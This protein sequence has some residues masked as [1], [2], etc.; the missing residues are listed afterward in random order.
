MSCRR[1]ILAVLL[2]LAAAP[3]AAVDVHDTRLLAEPD[4]SADR[5]VFTYAGDLWTA[6][7]AGGTA[8]RLTADIGRERRPRF[9]PDGSLVAFSAEYDGNVDVYVIPAGGGEPRR[10][11]WH[12]GDDLVQG[13]TP[14]GSAVLFTSQRSVHT[15]SIAQLFTVP[16]GGGFPERLPV[17]R[18]SKAELSPGGETVAYL[19]LSEAF[20]QWKHYRGGRA[21]RIWLQDLD[22]ASVLQIP[23]PE[24]RCNDTDP[25]WAGGR[26]FFLS[27][28]DGEFNLY[29]FDR[30]AGTVE[31]RTFH[32]DFPVAS[33]AAGPGGIVY[34]QAGRLH[35][36]DPETGESRPLVVGVAADLPEARSRW[37]AGEEWIRHWDL[38]PSGAR[39]VFEFRGEIV[40]VPAEKGDPRNLTRTPGAHDRWPAWSPD[41]AR[42]AWFSDAGGEQAL[43]VAPAGGAGEARVYPLAG[44]GFYDRPLWSPDGTKIAFS[45]NAWALYWIDLDSGRVRE[46]SREVV[47]GPSKALRYDWSPDSRWLAFTRN[48]P[49]LFQELW[50]H[51]LD[52]GDDHLVTDGLSDAVEPAFD[53]GGRHLYFAASTD[54][55]PLRQWFAMSNADMEM[56][57][58][59]YVAVLRAGDPSPLAPESD[60]E[61][62]AAAGDEKG[63]KKDHPKDR[64]DDDDGDEPPRVTV[65]AAG[66]GQRI[67][68]LPLDAA[69]Y[70]DLQAG[71][72]GTLHYL[73][74]TGGRGRRDRGAT[75]QLCR[76]DLEEREEKVLVEDADAYRLATGG[77]K[78]LVQVNGAWSI[79]DA[80]SP[81]PGEGRLDV[82]AVRVRVVP[83]EEW[84]QICHEAWRINRDCFY[85]P[86]M[87]G[88]DWPGVR[89]KYAAFLP[90]LSC[91]DDLSRVLRWMGSELS[92]GHHYLWGGDHRR[93]AEAVPG[94]LLGADYEVAEGRYRFARVLGGLNWNPELR[95]PLTEPGVDVREGEFLLAVDGVDLRPPE[96]L[97]ARFENTAGR[98]IALTVGP[99]ADGKDS[100][101]VQV[102]PVE[103]EAA[104]RHR[105]W[106]EGNLRR[107]EE[108]TG[109]RVAY[110][111]VPNTSTRGHEYFKRYFYPQADRDAIII[112]ERHNGGGQ[113]A[114]YY[115]DIL[116]RPR[117]CWWNT[118]YGRDFPTPL[119]AIQG[120]KVMLADETAGSGGDLLPWMFRKLELG[121]IVGRRTW[122]GL[123]GILGFPQLMDGAHITAP[124]LAI[125]TEDGFIV[126]NEG[127]PPDVEVEMLPAD[128]LAGRDPQ[129]EAAIAIVLEQLKK[130]PPRRP[131]RP[132][133]PLRALGA[134]DG[135]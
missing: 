12:P 77:E 103:S 80:G 64:D 44:A 121:T 15:R 134:Q 27:D 3:A 35:R 29:C 34:E 107:V 130:D 46:V 70:T 11:T 110:V 49:T 30:A 59:L 1:S 85:D 95:A 135:R 96:N 18:A 87:H 76:F 54:A 33:A 79:C 24:G 83:R 106:V 16:V 84:P 32:E 123:V 47:F 117:I 119:A 101:T 25:M 55:G 17:P 131:Q 19:P 102:V 126:E 115:I 56:T 71:A 6:P 58:S 113:V 60:E 4:C 122:G 120:P 50:L 2:L 43:H 129:L 108:A 73:K 57:R 38:S 112:D 65:D 89:E 98:I 21:S 127:V 28:R 67:L 86:G 88:A 31:Q 14:D 22:D 62:T 39:A 8:R 128:L 74:R 100:R 132:P 114:D 37:A 68:A 124:N 5:V 45:D 97:Y 125:W 42:I 104:L 66:L 105:A 118:R 72:A 7:L 23:Q 53:A 41:G 99:R 90:H 51:D 10:L 111:Y 40:T 52:S 133:Y 20:R 94:G 13:F 75:T 109:G 92:V 116:R 81:D 78:L 36:F 69:L 82:A 48:T 63:G 26:F 9:S 61:A 91:R 93:E